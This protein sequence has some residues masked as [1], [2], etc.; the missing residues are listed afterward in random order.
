MIYKVKI[1]RQSKAGKTA[2]DFVEALQDKEG[3]TCLDI[4]HYT[5]E[6]DS[7][8]V[9]GRKAYEFIKSLEDKRGISFLTERNIL[10]N[11]EIKELKEELIQLFE[12]IR[13]EH[14]KQRLE[15]KILRKYGR[16]KNRRKD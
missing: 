4:E 14:A 15:K 7:F 10:T 3:I 6:I 11:K 12:D 2:Y 1:D 16:K 8:T 13:K 5:L 9:S